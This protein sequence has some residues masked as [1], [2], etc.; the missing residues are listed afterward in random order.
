MMLK[1]I[2]IGITI[3]GKW[4]RYYGSIEDIVND[5]WHLGNCS[6]VLLNPCKNG[7]IFEF[8]SGELVPLNIDLIF[9][10]LHG[11]YGEDGAMQGL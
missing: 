7:G 9:P 6:D 10:V 1:I 3:D 4:L 8:N 5:T 2:N 11:R